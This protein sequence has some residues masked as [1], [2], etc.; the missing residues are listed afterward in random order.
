MNEIGRNLKK[1]RLLKSLSLKEA[2][3]LLNMS[4]TAISKYEKGNIVP[5]SLKLREFANAY[6]VKTIDL[7]KT[8]NYLFEKEGIEIPFPQVVVNK[9]EG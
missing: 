3:N 6:D 2:G 7:I 5:D 9:A 4:P 1:I 8:Y